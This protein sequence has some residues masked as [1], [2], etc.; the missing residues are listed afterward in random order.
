MTIFLVEQNA[1]HALRLSDRAYVMVTGEIRMT[2]TG[3][4]L[5]G[6]QEVREAYL[7]GH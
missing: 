6:N 4:E 3:E 1:N 5:L 7:G 2:G